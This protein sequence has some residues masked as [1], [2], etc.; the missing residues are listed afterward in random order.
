[1][2][3]LNHS[4]DLKGLGRSLCFGQ[5]LRVLSP[6]YLYFICVCPTVHLQ[7]FVD[8]LNR[9]CHPVLR[10]CSKENYHHHHHHHHI[11]VMELGHLLTRSGLT[12]PEVLQRSYHD[13]FCQLGSSTSLPRVIYH[14]HHHVSVMELGH[15]LPVPVSRIQKSL[16]RS[17]MIPSASCGP[18]AKGSNPTTGLTLLWARNPFR[19][20]AH[21]GVKPERAGNT[22]TPGI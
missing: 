3:G 12:Y 15:L 14:H 11:S 20:Y 9:I 4:L 13:F 21:P 1:M 18:E 6:A 2:N 8:T 7:N 19:T 22:Q 17:T 10:E 5:K 16:Q